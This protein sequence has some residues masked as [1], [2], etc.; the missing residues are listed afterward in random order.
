M[1]NPVYQR[2][3]NRNVSI[4]SPFDGN[5]IPPKQ[6]LVD[7]Y[8]FPVNPTKMNPMDNDFKKVPLAGRVTEIG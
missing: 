4:E 7:D 5:N 3:K 2:K 1:C 6:Y 8:A